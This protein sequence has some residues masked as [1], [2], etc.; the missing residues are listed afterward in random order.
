[1]QGYCVFLCVCVWWILYFI[2]KKINW[3]QASWVTAEMVCTQ[4]ANWC[5][6][7][8]AE[9]EYQEYESTV[10]LHV[11]GAALVESQKGEV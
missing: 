5:P 2:W 11:N 6:Y 7:G 3:C 4:K 1:M 9:G 8:T 10:T